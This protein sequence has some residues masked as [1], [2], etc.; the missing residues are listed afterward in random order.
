MRFLNSQINKNYLPYIQI[1]L[2]QRQRR[3]LFFSVIAILILIILIAIFKPNGRLEKQYNSMSLV[4]DGNVISS[5]TPPIISEN[6]VLISYTD[7]EKITKN[8]FYDSN[9]QKAVITST[10][11]VIKIKA[12]K[13]TGSVN[14]RPFGLKAVMKIQNGEAYIPVDEFKDV[15]NI[16]AKYVKE[17]NVVVVDTKAKDQKTAVLK[18]DNE[19]VRKDASIKQPIYKKVVKG[20]KLRIFG[21]KENWYKVRTD[22]GNIGYIQKKYLSK[23]ETIPY[24]KA[25]TSKYQAW[26]PSDGK[27][28][29]V[30]DQIERVTPSMDNVNKVE[31]LDVISPTWFQ[32]VDGTGRIKNKAD[33]AYVRWARANGYKVWPLVNNLV[34]NDQTNKDLTSKFLNN[35]D[36][37]EKVIN[38]LL[39]YAQIYDFDGINI[40]FEYVSVKDKE[41]LNQFMRELT[42]LFREKGLTVSIDVT[43]KVDSEN[44]L[45]FDR[46][47][48]AQIVDYVVAMS[49]DQHWSTSQ[50]S[51]S[52]AQYSWVEEHLKSL[53]E[54]I[55]KEKLIMGIPFYT[56]QWKE[57]NSK[58][59]SVAMSMAKTQNVI[60][61]NNANVTWD[62]AS[63]QHYAEYSNGDSKYKIWIEDSDSINW[64]TSLALKYNLAGAGAW[65]RG[66]ETPDIW[67]VLNKNLKEIKTYEQWPKK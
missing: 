62:E 24:K 7:L 39:S 14:N 18:A 64:K 58:V 31:G 61:Q 6:Y 40:D 5:K 3:G 37:R 20:E 16:D 52:V 57:Q 60:R 10:D 63:K 42:P 21:E 59:S 30:W 48:L 46:K 22:N 23:I 17:N 1:K 55:P 34:T 25:E 28:S 66:Y 9:L 45:F 12:D 54:D 8:V 4:I 65:R 2:S 50:V 43:V 26:K 32:I 53:L 19:A 38:D 49:Y 35:S 47:A 67:Q 51:G 41:M 13:N 29:L 56:R 36:T 44:S 27:I 15:L 33:G 11:K